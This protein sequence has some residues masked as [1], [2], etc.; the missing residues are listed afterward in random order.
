MK[1]TFHGFCICFF[2]WGLGKQSFGSAL[3]PHLRYISNK[4]EEFDDY[5]PLLFLLLQLIYDNNIIL[6]STDMHLHFGFLVTMWTKGVLT[7]LE[8]EKPELLL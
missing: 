1:S 3:L 2:F 6:T 7:F 8:D 4:R 5:L